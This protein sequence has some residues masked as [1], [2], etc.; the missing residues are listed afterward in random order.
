[1]PRRCPRS[2]SDM[3][4]TPEV[5]RML[6]GGAPREGESARGCCIG[7]TGGRVSELRETRETV[8]AWDVWDVTEG[9]EARPLRAV[10]GVPI[11][12]K[13][14]SWSSTGLEVSD[15]VSM[16]YFRGQS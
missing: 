1:M 4:D 2:V 3:L 6:S 5:I 9:E 14:V 16:E 13:P 11:G 15:V 7:E 12:T 10:W 8:L